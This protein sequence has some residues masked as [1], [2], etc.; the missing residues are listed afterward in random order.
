VQSVPEPGTLGLAGLSLVLLSTTV[1][2]AR[3]IGRSMRNER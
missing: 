3:R 1:R 2:G